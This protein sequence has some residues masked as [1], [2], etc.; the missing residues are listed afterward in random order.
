[1]YGIINIIHRAII[2]IGA[3]IPILIIYIINKKKNYNISRGYIIK[4][5][6]IIFI[7]FIIFAK[8]FQFIL[9]KV[10][11]DFNIMQVFNRRY[12][13]NF[14][15]SGYSFFGGYVGSLLAIGIIK[16]KL[17]IN[18][19]MC[20]WMVNNLNLMYAIMKI[21]CLLGGCCYGF[22]IIPVQLIESIISL[23]IYIF[24]IMFFIKKKQSCRCIG[25]SIILFSAERFVISFYRAYMTNL[26][27]LGIET[28]CVILIVVGVIICLK[29]KEDNVIKYY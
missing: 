18:K 12:I 28:I 14:I 29:N 27:F 13:T 23:I 10:Y 8:C 19:K 15:F 26:A 1:M 2:L 9:D 5:N 25:L 3:I 21:G 22:T 4:I 7:M 24:M 17:N 11:E 20:F 6:L 16:R